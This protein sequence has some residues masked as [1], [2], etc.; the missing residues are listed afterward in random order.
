MMPSTCS[1]LIRA[2]SLGRK[3]SEWNAAAENC[4]AT[5]T[6]SLPQTRKGTLGDTAPRHAC[7]VK[8]QVSRRCGDPS[9][10]HLRKRIKKQM[11][12]QSEFLHG[13]LKPPQCSPAEAPWFS[14]LQ[15]R[16]FHRICDNLINFPS[17]TLGGI[18]FILGLETM[19]VY[20]FPKSCSW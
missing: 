7:S 9:G 10:V 19:C 14:A 11:R 5:E 4:A 12:F 2:I 3:T 20:Q 16:A 13:F 18:N 15:S 1:R 6:A 17:S 8:I